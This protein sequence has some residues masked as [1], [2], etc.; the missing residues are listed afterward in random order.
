M[1]RL[2]E[3]LFKKIESRCSLQRDRALSNNLKILASLTPLHLNNLKINL[4]YP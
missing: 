3:F 2:T 1:L 4:I